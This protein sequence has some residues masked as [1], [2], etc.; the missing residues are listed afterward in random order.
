M[1]AFWYSFLDAPDDTEATITAKAERTAI[2]MQPA[3]RI[4][5]VLGEQALHTR[6]GS[7]DDH[8]HQLTHLLSLIRLPYLSVGIIPAAH[9][10]SAL[11]T[12]GFWIFDNDAVAIETPT[13]A[14]KITRP[15]EIALYAA[16]FKGLQSEAVYGDDARRLIARILADL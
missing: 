5:V 4:A 13:A 10:R 12:V 6:F 2:A 11:A 8:A 15:T 16:M 3:K 14:I 1:L 7:V 9:Q